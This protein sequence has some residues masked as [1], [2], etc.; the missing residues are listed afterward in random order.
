MKV[1]FVGAGRWALALGIR[2]AE[3]GLDVSA[4]GV[5]PGKPG[6]AAHD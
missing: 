5:Q 1:A 3:K 4:L 2:L 6:P